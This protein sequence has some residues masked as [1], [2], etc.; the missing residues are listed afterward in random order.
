[1]HYLVG[2]I[3]IVVGATV[4]ISSII[5]PSI[6]SVLVNIGIANYFTLAG[7][8]ISLFGSIIVYWFSLA[9]IKFCRILRME[10]QLQS[11]SAG[12]NETRY[13]YYL[14]VNHK[15]E[16]IIE[17]CRAVPLISGREIFEQQQQRDIIEKAFDMSRFRGNSNSEQIW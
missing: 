2:V 15:R 16:K 8:I 1:M 17:S 10:R 5:V 13:Q 7:G 11:G 9:E 3:I 6:R 4:A 14:R 12:S